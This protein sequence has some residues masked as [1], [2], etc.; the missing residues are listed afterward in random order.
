VFAWLKN[1]KAP[2]AG[3]G[4]PLFFKDN[5]AAFAFACSNLAQ[6]LKAG[7]YLPALVQDGS[8]FLVGGASVQRN[9]DR[10]QLALLSVCSADGGF[11]LLASS[12]SPNGP[13]LKPDDLVIWQAGSPVAAL[14]SSVSDQ[15]SSWAGLIVAKLL[16]EYTPGRGWAVMEQF[17]P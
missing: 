2:P 10:N 12:A 16:P 6:E 8:T 15:R 9:P 14:S 13:V 3:A 1:K 7:I 17:K 5:A 4:V 11:P